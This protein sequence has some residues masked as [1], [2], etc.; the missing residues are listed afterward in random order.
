MSYDVS[1]SVGKTNR[2]GWRVFTGY[3]LT[4]YLAVHVGYTDLGEAQT[5]LASSGM[6]QV[7]L[8]SFERVGVQSVRGVDV[9]LQL[10]LPVTGRIDAEVRGGKYFWQSDTRAAGHWGE[11][12]R[13]P[14]HSSTRDSDRFFGAGIEVSVMNDLSATLG[15]TRYKVGSEPVGLWTVGAL[16]R[17]GIY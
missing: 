6:E 11:F 12:Q 1:A 9:G 4:N 15:W 2:V 14:Y 8:P 10:K 16:Y 13:E 7:R 17:F 5:R 3:R